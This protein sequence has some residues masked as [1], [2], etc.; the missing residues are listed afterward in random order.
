MIQLFILAENP[1]KVKLNSKNMTLKG[2]II[3]NKSELPLT[4]IEGCALVWWDKKL[5]LSQKLELQKKWFIKKT[6]Y[7]LTVEDIQQMW[8]NEF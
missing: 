7:T 3:D 2:C 8:Q 5:T 1:I 4:F 6:L